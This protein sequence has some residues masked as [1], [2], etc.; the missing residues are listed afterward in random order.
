MSEIDDRRFLLEEEFEANVQH[1]LG[2]LRER[3]AELG[4]PQVFDTLNK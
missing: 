2:V 1:D 4:D 3:F